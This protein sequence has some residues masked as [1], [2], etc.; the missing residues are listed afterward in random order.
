MGRL[1][2]LS[3]SASNDI[4]AFV[5]NTQATLEPT[6]YYLSR[7]YLVFFI[8]FQSFLNL[9]LASVK[10][11]LNCCKRLTMPGVTTFETVCD[12]N[13]IKAT[14][15]RKNSWYII[16]YTVLSKLLFVELIPWITV[17]VLNYCT[18][19]RLKK[20]HAVRERAFGSNVQ[21][22]LKTIFKTNLL[23]D[24]TSHVCF[25]TNL[26]MLLI[27]ERSSRQTRIL[28]GVV[29]VFIFCQSFTL[30]ADLYEFNCCFGHSE[31]CQSNLHIERFIDVAH[32]VLAINSTTNFVFYM[33]HIKGFRNSFLKV[34]IY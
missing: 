22:K 15:L 20:F 4:A 32:L 33:V 7:F 27:S 30:V 5:I 29:L 11:N 12:P 26:S 13:G 10:L 16:F 9:F 1:Q 17:I 6:F 21:R 19:R 14:P 3:A 18:W 25:C 34:Y 28:M 31:I 2:L 24:I 8:T 23:Y